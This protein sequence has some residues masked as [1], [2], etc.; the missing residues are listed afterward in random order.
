M[1]GKN[2]RK[3][4]S[5]AKWG[6]IF[7]IPFFVVYAIFTLY[8]QILTFYNSFFDNYREGLTQIGPNFVGFDN[9]IKLFTTSTDGMIDIVKYFSNTMNYV[10]YRGLTTVCDSF[11]SGFNLYKYQTET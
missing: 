11:T 2:N 9:Y 6:Y 8:P 1:R 3:S 4:V 10:D 7:I 5:Y